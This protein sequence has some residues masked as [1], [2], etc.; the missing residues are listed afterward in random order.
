MLIAKPA[1]IAATVAPTV[2]GCIFEILFNRIPPEMECGM[3]H[4][5]AD[6]NP[7]PVRGS[8]LW[9]Q[10]FYRGQAFVF[11]GDY[12]LNNVVHTAATSSCEYSHYHYQQQRQRY[13]AAP[14]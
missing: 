7:P 4:W 5:P 1:M 10:A 12:V 14:L 9:R 13:L 3:A 6:I 8:C 11:A 2:T